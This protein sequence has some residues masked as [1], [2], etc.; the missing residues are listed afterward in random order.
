MNAPGVGRRRQDERGAFWA[1][2]HNHVVGVPL[3]DRAGIRTY[4]PKS[5]GVYLIWVKLQNGKWRCFYV[6]QALDLEE[7]LL[8]H[9]SPSNP[10]TCIQTHVRDHICGFEF[11]KVA[12]QSDRDGI[13][14][15]LYDHF[16]PECNQQVPGGTAI[17]VNVP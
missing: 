6:G 9:L 17:P 12:R 8:T 1:R 5:P 2:D 15:F 7:R 14:K 3:T 16:R 10:N 4:V 11:A 13:E